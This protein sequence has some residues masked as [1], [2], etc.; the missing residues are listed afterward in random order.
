MTEATPETQQLP[1]PKRIIK[2]EFSAE[3]LDGTKI[4]ELSMDVGDSGQGEINS[5]LVAAYVSKMTLQGGG[6]LKSENNATVFYPM[7][8][9]KKLIIEKQTVSGIQLA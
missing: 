1:E 9:V 2:V 5:H 6:I 8:A 3:L 7:S 4:S